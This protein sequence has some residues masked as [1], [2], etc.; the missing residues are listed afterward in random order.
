MIRF[1]LAE[2]SQ[3]MT[4]AINEMCKAADLLRGD[5]ECFGSTIKEINEQI[6][7]MT[8]AVDFINSELREVIQ[9]QPQRARVIA[10]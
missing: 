8:I 9:A 7:D 5:S 1:D 3:R 4:N 2:A 10:N 6:V